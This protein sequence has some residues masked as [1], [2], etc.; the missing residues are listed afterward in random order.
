MG[1]PLC[2]HIFDR[3]LKSKYIQKTYVY[4]SDPAIKQYIPQPVQFLRR[5]ERLDKDEVKGLEIYQAFVK[6][7]KANVYVLAH[8]TSPFIEIRSIDNAIEKVISGDYDSAFSAQEIQTFVWYDGRPL[9]YSLEDIPRTQDI[10]PVLVETSAF[11][12]FKKDIIEARRRIGDQPWIEI[13][14]NIEALDI[15]TKEDYDI[16]L[17]IGGS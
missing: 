10:K 11:Y 7:V 16:A 8:A 1:R 9:N 17:R 3:L 12:I 14:S 5:S 15:D 2:Y 13:V 6:E 4:C